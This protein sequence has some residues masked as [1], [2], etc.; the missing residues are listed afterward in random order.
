MAYRNKIQSLS[1]WLAH[2]C[3]GLLVLLPALS[4]LIWLK[5][6]W[7]P[8]IFEDRYDVATFDVMT[9]I[10]GVLFSLL[11]LA[12]WLFGL[13]NLRRL[14]KNYALGQVFLLENAIYIRKFAWVSIIGGGLAPLFG[15]VYSVILSMNHAD[16]ERFLSVN[17]G[18]TEIHTILLGL[19]FVVIS[20]VM[21]E[22]QSLS[23]ENQQFV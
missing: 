14:F 22:A 23:A 11:P 5:L 2:V 3:T 18:T 7:F 6:D 1:R 20:H 12:I 9:Q 10:Y 21:E 19:V 4:L 15:G 8:Q 13:I 16:G 17:I